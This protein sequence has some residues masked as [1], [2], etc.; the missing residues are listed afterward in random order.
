MHY[1]SFVNKLLV[2]KHFAILQS[3]HWT[4]R[5]QNNTY[6]PKKYITNETEGYRETTQHGSPSNWLEENNPG[7][8]C[9]MMEMDTS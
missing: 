6:V 5:Y 2:P 4:I 1:I 9:L 3:F 8:I 7:E